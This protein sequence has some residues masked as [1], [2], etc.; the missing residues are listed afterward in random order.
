MREFLLT[1]FF[2]LALFGVAPLCAATPTPIDVNICDLLTDLV[3]WD[4]QMVRFEATIYK[5]DFRECALHRRSGMSRADSDW[6]R[7]VSERT[8]P[9]QNAGGQKTTHPRRGI[10]N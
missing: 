9:S 3:K 2:A 7:C 5:G 10:S 6:Q 4:G 1:R 8:C